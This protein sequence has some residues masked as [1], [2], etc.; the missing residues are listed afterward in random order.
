MTTLKMTVDQRALAQFTGAMAQLPRNVGIKHL[1]IALN[2]W[3]GEVKNEAVANVATDTKLLRRSLGVRVV[4]PDASWD[5]RHH[6]RPSRVIVGARRKF[7]AL[8]SRKRLKSGRIKIRYRIARLAATSSR[9]KRA[10]RY[11][12]IAEDQQDYIAPAQRVGNTRGLAKLARK[13]GQGITLEAQ[14]LAA[15]QAAKRP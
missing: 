15:R 5:V 14:K 12:H 10:S 1:R 8:R 2:A 13:L 4:I 3:G 6:G 9:V 7:V 11:H